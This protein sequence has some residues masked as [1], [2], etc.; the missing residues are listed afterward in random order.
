MA[1]SYY[2]ILDISADAETPEIRRAYR[3]VLRKYHPDLNPNQ[4]KSAKRSRQLNAALGVLTNPAERARYDAKLE[5]IEKREKKAKEKS[6]R[7]NSRQNTRSTEGETNTNQKPKPKP[8][9]SSSNRT[10]RQPGPRPGFKQRSANSSTRHSSGKKH[11]RPEAPKWKKKR[12]R[13]RPAKK[14]PAY[15]WSRSAKTFKHTP[16]PELGFQHGLGIGI[17]VGTVLI[18]LLLALLV[19]GGMIEFSLINR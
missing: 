5:R 1:K 7:R 3:N 2:E 6:K 18:I 13:K 10:N 14:S 16:K 9:P 11:Q 4:R 12:G 15:R 17:F 8:K 19:F